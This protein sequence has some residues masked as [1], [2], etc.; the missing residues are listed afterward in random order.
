MILDFSDYLWGI[1]LLLLIGVI[2]VCISSMVGLASPATS[3][4]AKLARIADSD[5]AGDTASHEPPPV[6][7]PWRPGIGIIVSA[8][9]LVLSVTKAV[10]DREYQ[11]RWIVMAMAAGAGM[12]WCIGLV[13]AALRMAQRIGLMYP[14][15]Q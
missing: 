4:A 10:R 5:R 2:V 13:S 8:V 3:R 14:N 9:L 6:M 11:S 12:V 7:N 15:M 1:A